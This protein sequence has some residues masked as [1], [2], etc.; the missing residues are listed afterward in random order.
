MSPSQPPSQ[1]PNQ[2]SSQ[3]SPYTQYY[4]RRLLRQYVATLNYPPA[5]VGIRTYFQENLNELLANIYPALQ[6]KAKLH[7]LELLVQHHQLS[8]MD[9]LHPYGNQHDIE[10]KI[11]WI[12]DLRFLALLP[13]LPL[14]IVPEDT[15]ARFHFVLEDV[16]HEGIRHTDDLF[17]RV[18]E[19]GAEHNLQTYSLML[20]LINQQVGFILTVSE[21]RHAIWVNLRSP[22]YY[23]L[24]Q[25]PNQ[26]DGL[27]QIA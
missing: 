7:E 1:P 26:L 27:Q 15:T 11:L 25:Q 10:Q 17:G 5:G 21:L 2:P 6:L 4:I 13:A 18:L 23:R 12:L 24:V 14:A 20:T 16:M 22:I 8:E 19:F 9:G 3:L